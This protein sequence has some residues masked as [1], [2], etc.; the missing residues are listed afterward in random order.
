MRYQSLHH[1]AHQSIS[2]RGPTLDYARRGN[3]SSLWPKW[4]MALGLIVGI[5]LQAYQL[6]EV[7]SLA[8]IRC[9]S[10]WDLFFAT[11]WL[12]AL[13]R[14]ERSRSWI[15]YLVLQVT[16][17]LWFPVLAHWFGRL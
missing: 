5:A 6:S 4:P 7:D 17:A 14:E 16:F 15:I 9:A 10:L 8:L 1:T 12:A 2:D 3:A 13:W 11:R